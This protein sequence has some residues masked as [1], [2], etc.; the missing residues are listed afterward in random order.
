VLYEDE[1]ENRLLES[2]KVFGSICNNQY[3]RKTPVIL[4]LNK[5]DL[6]KIKIQRVPLR[7]CFP[8]YAEDEKNEELARNYIHDRVRLRARRRAAW[9]AV[10]PLLLRRPQFVEQDAHQKDIFCHFTCATDTDNVERVFNDCKSVILKKNL[11][12]LGLA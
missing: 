8:E 6:F 9:R 5:I 12:K 4:F 1:K 7:V 10:S 3:F 2:I 11:E